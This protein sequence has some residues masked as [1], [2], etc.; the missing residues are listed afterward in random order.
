M[1]FLSVTYTIVKNI[2]ENHIPDFIMM[3]IL[4]VFANIAM[5]AMKA[6]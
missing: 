2:E 3:K 4:K 5:T 6:R 1:H